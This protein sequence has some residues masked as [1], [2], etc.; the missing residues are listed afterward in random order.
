MIS[1]SIAPWLSVKNSAKAVEFYKAAFGA[2]E[3]Y[4][5]DIPDGTVV[6]QLKID[7][8]AFWISEESP[9]NS[10]PDLTSAADT[11]IRMILTVSDPDPLFE[12]V[13]EAGASQVYPVGE[14]HGW[15]LGR[16]VDP[17]GHHWEIGHPLDNN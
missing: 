7:G 10:N 14:E 11:A 16:L 15:R 9:G 6:A 2:I 4:R 1:T 12:R 5:L 17:F 8:A 13:L 3:A